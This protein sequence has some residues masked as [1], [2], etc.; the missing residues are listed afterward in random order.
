MKKISKYIILY[1]S[2]MAVT[3]TACKKDMIDMNTNEELLVSTD[4]RFVFTSATENWNNMDRT[5]LMSKYSGVMTLMQYVVSNG[6]GSEG[7]YANPAELSNPSPYLPYYSYYYS[8]YGNRLRYL[9]EVVIPERVDK[10]LYQEIAA[11]SK[12]LNA[13]QAFQVFDTHGAI[14]YTEA[15]Q[16]LNGIITPK[17]DMYEDIYKELDQTIASQIDVLNSDLANQVSLGNND[18]FFKGDKT[19]WIKFANTLRIKMAQRFEKVDPSHYNAVI[20]NA[21]SHPVGLISNNTESCVYYHNIEH[22]NDTWD[23]SILTSQYSASNAFT[24]FLKDNNDPRL[25]LLVR[26]NGFGEGNNNPSNDALAEDL[27]TYFPNF[28]TDPQFS[29]YAERYVGIPASPDYNGKPES[30]DF[31][32]FNTTVDGEAYNFTIRGASQI[33][34]RYFVKN[35]GNATTAA[36]ERNIDYPRYENNDDMKMFTPVLTFAETCFMLAE[37]SEKA[38]KNIGGKSAEQ[39][40]TDGITASMEEYQKWGVDM[41]VLAAANETADDYAPITSEAI[42][43]Y[44]SQNQIQYSGSKE[45]KLELIISQAWINYFMRP[46]EA[47][48]TWKRTGLPKFK[49]YD[50]PNPKDGTAFLDEITTGG[51]ELLIPRR[52][53]LPVPNAA[54]IVNYQDALSRLTSQAEY[55]TDGKTEGRIFWDKP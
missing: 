19:K 10:D 41:K 23:I 27:S 15:L 2:T 32:S 46:E 14:P 35:G 31:I 43:D 51:T 38:G 50:T 37:I 12:I 45:R 54:N 26:K 20:E 1:L 49:A 7:S 17:Y 47:Y 42:S 18:F 9:T 39:W 30:R 5:S 40:Y 6:G 16:G 3:F 34:S 8:V 53:R 11:I 36:G 28:D 21:T 29:K 24:S 44:L 48:A 25:P 52:S 4:P 55:L 33:Q 13:Y 22:N